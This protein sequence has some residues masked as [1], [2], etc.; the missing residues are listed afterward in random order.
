MWIIK[1]GGS[2]IDK[3]ELNELVTHLSKHSKF[4]NIIIV[5]GGGCFADAVRLVYASNQMSEKTGHFLALKGT[6]MFAHIIK[7]INKN[8]SLINNIESLKVLDRKLKVWMPSRVLKDEPS[9]I[10]SWESTSDSV[11]AWL[12]KKVKSKGLIFVKSLIFEKK[13]YKLKHLQD[14]NVL[15]RNVDKYL[16]KQKNIKIVGPEII[17]LFKNAKDWK[18]F[19]FDL[20]E[21]QL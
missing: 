20:N 9:F 21:V 6:E 17:D 13:K 8:I 11:A 7:E 1:I 14:K 5:V 18:E 16:Y 3:V 4:E 10:N 12:H 19:Y 2:W 15:D